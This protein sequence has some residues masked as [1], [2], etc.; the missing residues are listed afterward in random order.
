MCLMALGAASLES[1]DPSGRSCALPGCPNIGR[2]VDVW[3][4]GSPGL[5]VSGK[6]QALLP[7]GVSR[8]LQPP[9]PSAQVTVASPLLQA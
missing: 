7:R 9:E 6:A 2:W 5:Q 4:L 1:Q 3:L 8:L